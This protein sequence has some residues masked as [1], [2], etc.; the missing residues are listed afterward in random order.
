[1]TDEDT[2]YVGNLILNGMG[3]GQSPRILSLIPT[4][5]EQQRGSRS[6][7]RLQGSEED[8]RIVGAV[9][10]SSVAGSRRGLR[11]QGRRRSILRVRVRSLSPNSSVLQTATAS[12]SEVVNENNRE[13]LRQ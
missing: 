13:D 5:V 3:D 10:R 7:Q 9:R 1:M 2:Y 8:L 11:P 4:R 12:H 6:R